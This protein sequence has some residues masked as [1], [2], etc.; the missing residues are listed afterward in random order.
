MSALLALM[1]TAVPDAALLQRLGE[2]G[3]RMDTFAKNASFTVDVVAE[4]FDSD[5]K[6]TKTTKSS[7]RVTRRDGKESRKLTKY[8]EDGVDLTEKKRAE[9]EKAE[10]KPVHSPFLPSQQAKYRF[11]LLESKDDQLRIGIEPAGKKDPELIT[12]EA[13]VDPT[14]G[15]VRFVTMAP[16]KMPAFVDSLTLTGTFDE[17]S[18]TKLTIKGVGGFLFIKKRFGVVTIFRD[19]EARAD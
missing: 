19:Y 5:G 8:T 12:G 3:K 16:S 17:R 15:E 18:M 4:E 10:S 2:H 11:T 14:T 7:M 13:K 1:L 9:I 6:A